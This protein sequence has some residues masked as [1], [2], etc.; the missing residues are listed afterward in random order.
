MKSIFT[1]LLLFVAITLISQDSENERKWYD[2]IKFTGYYQ[3]QYHFTDKP[4]SLSL[5]SMTAGTFNRF[6][7]NKFTVRRSRLRLEYDRSF[8]TSALSFDITERGF[9]IKDAWLA[10]EEQKWNAFKLHLGVFALPFGHEIELQSLERE[11]PE[12]SRVIQ[13]LFPGI[14]DIGASFT[15]RMP[16]KSPYHFIQLDAG[17]FHGTHGN[18]ESDDRKD[19]TGRLKLHSP[20]KKEWIDFS[21]AYSHYYGQVRHQYDI[22]G[23]ISNY[24]YIFNVIDT[25]ITINDRQ[26]N[27]IILFQD[28]FPSELNEIIRDSVNP[29]SPATYSRYVPRKYH[30][31]STE[32]KLDF[33]VK[34]KKIGKTILRGEYVWGQ[35]VSQEGTLGNPY[36]FTSESPTGPYMS[37]TWPKFDSPQP[38]NPAGI[39]MHIKPSHTFVRQFRGMYIYWDQ[40]IA[41]TK[42]HF[43]YKYDFYDPNTQ[44]AGEQIRLVLNDENGVPYGSTGLSSADVAYTTHGFGYRYVHNERLS[45][46]LYY[47]R[48]RNEITSIEPLG[49]AQINLGKFPSTGFL[50][51]VKDDVFTLR[52]QYIF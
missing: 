1:L 47:E 16:E 6:N 21:V 41:N 12:R 3:F 34:E 10:L 8:A 5:H 43:V 37:V 36:V 44:V 22:D 20:F 35:Q 19:Y 31:V 39:G 42:H 45:L 13:T 27:H 15:F 32:I 50:E 7:N 49:S 17:I 29:I 46:M 40:Q 18:L 14:R 23:S 24:H 28:Y 51:D 25:T 30:S 48:P 26:E 11:T 52:I 2:D 4:D 33:K 38:Y 9:R